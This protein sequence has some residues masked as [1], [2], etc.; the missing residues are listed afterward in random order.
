MLDCAKEMVANC[1]EVK[2]ALSGK[3]FTAISITYY[4]H[5]MRTIKVFHAVDKLTASVMQIRLS[6][7][8]ANENTVI[9]KTNSAEN[10]HTHNTDE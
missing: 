8:T 7:A 1:D 5:G 3:L 6:P 4:I 9:D 2:K 10:G